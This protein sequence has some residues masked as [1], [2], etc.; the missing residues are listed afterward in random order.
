MEKL[1]SAEPWWKFT[2][3]CTSLVAQSLWL[4]GPVWCL[5][6]N[7]LDHSTLCFFSPFSICFPSMTRRFTV[8]IPPPYLHFLPLF[9]LFPSFPY[10]FLAFSPDYLL[11]QIFDLLC[12]ASE[13]HAFPGIIPIII[14][15]TSS[16]LT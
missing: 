5:A 3:Y 8:S 15:I 7:L 12:S 2:H 16:I 9:P 13:K 1:N 14:I 11:Y 10:L 6:I 4:T